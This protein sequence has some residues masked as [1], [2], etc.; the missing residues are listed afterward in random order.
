M[1]GIEELDPTLDPPTGL[2]PQSDDGKGEDPANPGDGDPSTPSGDDGDT[3]GADDGESA[4]GP[5]AGEAGA[6]LADEI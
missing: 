6:E 5:A 2:P 1:S 3:S 4:S